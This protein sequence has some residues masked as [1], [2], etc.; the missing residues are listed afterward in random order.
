MP[1]KADLAASSH[2]AS[3]GPR[4]DSKGFPSLLQDLTL[5]YPKLQSVPC[6]NEQLTENFCL[7]PTSL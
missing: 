5:L 7:L 6:T 3:K 2:L 4:E 1:F